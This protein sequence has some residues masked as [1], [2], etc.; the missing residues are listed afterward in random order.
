MLLYEG[1]LRERELDI[2]TRK[3]HRKDK[4]GKYPVKKYCNSIFTFDNILHL[5]YN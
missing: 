3:A 4:S 1:Q 5:H 2:E